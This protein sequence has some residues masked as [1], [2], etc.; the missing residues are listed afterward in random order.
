M[1]RFNSSMRRELLSAY[2]F[3]R[4]GRS[5]GEGRRMDGRLQQSQTSQSARLPMRA[6]TQPEQPFGTSSYGRD[7][8][9]GSLQKHLLARS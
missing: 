6:Q 3:P 5:T 7:R 8:K 4:L 2:V 9:Q 1:E